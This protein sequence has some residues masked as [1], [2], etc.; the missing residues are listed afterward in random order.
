MCYV[1]VYKKENLLSPEFDY[2]YGWGG[3]NITLYSSHSTGTVMSLIFAYWY[4]IEFHDFA[5]GC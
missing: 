2:W 5:P 3:E 4:L 1:Q